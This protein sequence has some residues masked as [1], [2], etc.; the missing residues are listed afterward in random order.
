MRRK[1]TPQENS[2]Q[3]VLRGRDPGPWVPGRVYSNI[4]VDFTLLLPYL[5]SLVFDPK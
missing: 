1:I 5:P 4:P 3:D 2:Q